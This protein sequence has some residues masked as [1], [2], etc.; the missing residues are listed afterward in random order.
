M[1][2]IRNALRALLIG[3]DDIDGVITA[4]EISRIYPVVLPQGIILPSI[5]YNLITEGTDYHMQGPSGLIQARYQIDCW[6]QTQDAAVSLANLVKDKLSGFRG[7]VPFGSE[8]PQEEII[9]RG[10]FHD[11]GRDDYDPV[12]KL[13]RRQCDYLIW[14]ADR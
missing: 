5:V 6:A 10:V 9:I 13:F 1:K 4:S 14:Y 7:L 12:A 11:Q 8:S 2:D 3:D